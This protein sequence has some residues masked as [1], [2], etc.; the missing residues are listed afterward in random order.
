MYQ[1]TLAK[2]ELENKLATKFLD[3]HVQTQYHYKNYQWISYSDLFLP[4]LD[5]QKLLIG[6]L[7]VL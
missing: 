4:L 2:L 7:L 5:S 1:S 3:D 6:D